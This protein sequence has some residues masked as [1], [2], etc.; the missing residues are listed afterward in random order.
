M[1]YKDRVQQEYSREHICL[2]NIHICMQDLSMFH[3][4]E[5]TKQ[6]NC[7]SGLDVYIKYLERDFS[8]DCVCVKN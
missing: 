2:E 5:H 1:I 4:L 6:N 8:I 3:W 7:D